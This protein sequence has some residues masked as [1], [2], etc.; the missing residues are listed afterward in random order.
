MLESLYI[1]ENSIQ[2]NLSN[3]N[4][5]ELGPSLIRLAND[6]PYRRSL[7]EASMPLSRNG[8]DRIEVRDGIRELE[9]IRKDDLRYLAMPPRGRLVGDFTAFR[10]VLKVISPHLGRRNGQWRLH[11]GSKVN[12]YTVR[13]SQFLREVRDGI[14]SF[15]AGDFLECEVR[16]IQRI[17]EVGAI[18]KDFEILTV[19]RHLP[20][21]IG[22]SYD[23][24]STDHEFER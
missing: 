11:D 24:G 23:F 13:D 15:A 2:A 7:V 21:D 17:D 9:S 1:G 12:R 18:R 10:E 4:M 3:K 22:S 14:L 16:H 20:Q 5:Q 19:I 6:I 8:Y